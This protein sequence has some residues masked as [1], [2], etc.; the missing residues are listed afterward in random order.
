MSLRLEM[1]LSRLAALRL[2]FN[3]KVALRHRWK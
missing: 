2:L 3:P 1:A